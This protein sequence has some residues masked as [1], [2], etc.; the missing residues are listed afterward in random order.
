MIELALATAFFLAIHFGI[1]GTT[2]RDRLIA[3]LG[4]APYRG[5]F[6]LFVLFV[7]ALTA[8][9]SVIGVSPFPA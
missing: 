7:G 6:S 1:A 9:R 5:A 8:H 3:R 2:A 4:F